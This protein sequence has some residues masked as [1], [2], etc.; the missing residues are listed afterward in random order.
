MTHTSRSPLYRPIAMA[1]VAIA[2]AASTLP[3]QAQRYGHG[4]YHGRPAPRYDNRRYY[5]HRG[6]G[7]GNGGALIAG[8]LLGAIAGVAISNSTQQAPPPV[9]YSTAPPPPPPGVVY[10]PPPNGY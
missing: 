3:A 1:V 6:N 8:A 9:V 5:D 2:M 4:G 7:H 10:Y